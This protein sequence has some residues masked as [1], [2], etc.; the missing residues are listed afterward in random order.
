MNDIKNK[1][2]I[3]HIVKLF[4]K[5]LLNDAEMHHFF[6]HFLDEKEL[7]SHLR[8]LVD[9]WSN[10][11]FYTGDYR[12]NAMQIH[13]DIHKKNAMQEKHFNAWLSHFNDS[14]DALFK[15]ENAHAIKSRA[16]SIATVMKF[17]ISE[18]K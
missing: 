4:Y 7:E 17:K 3:Y 1:D 15:G 6:V 16:L 18:L 12:K 11:L 14:V 5:K 10:I 2:D 13:M 9:F 8:I